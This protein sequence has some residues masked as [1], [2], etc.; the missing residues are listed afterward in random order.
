ML[1][2]AVVELLLVVLWVLA[3]LV[4]VEMRAHLT[5]ELV[6][7]ELRVPVAV[8]VVEVLQTLLVITQAQQVVQ[9]S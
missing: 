7:L 1:A 8:A 2:A 4:A 9:V 6:L 5:A 3:A